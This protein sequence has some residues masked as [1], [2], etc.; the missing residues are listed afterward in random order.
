MT[1]VVERPTAAWADRSGLVLATATAA[2]LALLAVV[3][4]WRGSDFPAQLLRIDLFRQYGFVLWNGQWFGGHATVYYSV[5]LPPLGAWIGPVA[6]AGVSGIAAAVC[7]ERI[8]HRHFGTS[9]RVGA[10]W[11]AA[12][13][14]TNLVV[15][16]VTFSLGVAFA[17]GAVLALQRRRVVIASLCAL[18]CPLASPVAAIFLAIAVGGW[19]VARPSNRWRAAAVTGAAL[20][21]LGVMALLFPSSGRFPYEPWALAWDVGLCIVVLLLAP[22]DQPVVRWVAALYAVAV[23]VVYLV[24]SPLGENMSRFGQYAAGP[25]LACVLW[26]RRRLLLGALAV[27]LLFWQWFPA[28]DGVAFSPRDPST[29][30]AYYQ[31]LLD[32]LERAGDPIGRVEIPPTLRHWETVNV[33][34]HVPL[35]RG[36]ERQLDIAYNP[37]FYNG[38]LDAGA[39][40]SWLIDN[41]VRFV[42]LPD[43]DLD[44]SGAE[45]AR[46]L[47]AGLAYLTPVA[48]LPHWRVWTVNGFSGLVEGPARLDKMTVDSLTLEV[49]APGSVIVRVRASS[50]WAVDQPACSTDDGAGWLRLDGLVP[51]TVRVT[52]A[53]TGT[54]CK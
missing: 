44:S 7:F 4:G 30:S 52:Q 3:L 48:S 32:V 46:L 36:W 14:V 41:G 22:R 28:V 20:V 51:G 37:M 1:T 21:P 8:V 12:G 39:Y 27:P 54:P 49:L 50:H 6:L 16:R 34:I 38:T 17:L 23:I 45:E 35:A 13:T 29:S 42:A 53:V 10:A 19:G 43:A 25:V 31:S 40:Q 5:L 9:A 11:F 47:D 15:G 26:P 18:L 2:G 33:A 24:P